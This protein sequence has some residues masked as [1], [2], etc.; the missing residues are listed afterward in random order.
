LGK[1]LNEKTITDRKNG[2]R[3]TSYLSK[4]EQSIL[5]LVVMA[6]KHYF[7]A[8]K[9]ENE[10]G[11]EIDQI[12][13]FLKRNSGKAF[14]VHSLFSRIN[15]LGLNEKAKNNIDLNTLEQI[16]D[17]LSVNGKIIRQDK[18]GKTFYFFYL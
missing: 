3:L 15:D 2:Y 11:S 1:K 7:D 18:E 17:D 12:F 4:V 10:T 13:L 16:L 6:F 8:A 9:G 5:A 14:T